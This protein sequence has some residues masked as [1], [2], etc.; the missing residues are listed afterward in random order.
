MTPCV[1]SQPATAF[2]LAAFDAAESAAELLS[3]DIRSACASLARAILI[4]FVHCRTADGED[5]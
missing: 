2:G 4:D 5:L 3:A 1:Y